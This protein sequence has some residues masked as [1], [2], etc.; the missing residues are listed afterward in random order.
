[1]QQVMDLLRCGMGLN[2]FDR[3]GNADRQNASGMQR[4]A[5]GG[6]IGPQIARDRMDSQLAWP[7]DPCNGR[8]YFVHQGHHIA[9]IAGI[10]CGHAV[11]KDK[12][13]GRVRRDAGLTTKLC[14]TIALALDDGRD[15]EIVGI[16]QF[17]VEQCLAL[18]EPG[19]LLADVGMAAQGRLER[20]GDPL[21]L[22]VTERRRLVQEPLGLLPQR[23]NGCSKLQKLLLRVAHQAHQDS[24]LT[25]ALAAK[26]PHDFV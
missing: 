25:T 1:M 14:G 6:V 5:Y 4:L 9:G 12:A 2:G 24:A 21:A 16:D 17:T 13:R 26:A 18:G 3:L 23:G 20:R 7:R 15:G 8:L 19:G 11:R 10:R 22:G